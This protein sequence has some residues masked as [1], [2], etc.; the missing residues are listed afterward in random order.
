M[1][2]NMEVKGGRAIAEARVRTTGMTFARSLDMRYVGQEHLV[3]I[4]VAVEHF[5]RQ[6]RAAI[7]RLFDAEHEQRYG[8]SAPAEPAE[9]ASLRAAVIGAL[10]KPKFEHIARG[11]G[12]PPET[13][14]RGTRQAYF[15]GGFRETAVLDRMS[16]L[17]GNRILGP[18][19]VEEHAST[20]VLMPG[21]ELMV[22]EI[23]NLVIAVGS[24]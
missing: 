18:A 4:D 2:E 24:A 23:G 11:S 6:D 9:I 17:A 19:L 22:D 20:T 14:R 3:T 16:L 8:T 15:S 5:E 12:K 7:K 1:F 13:V 10:A 21:D